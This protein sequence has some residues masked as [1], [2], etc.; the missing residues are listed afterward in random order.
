[1]KLLKQLFLPLLAL[2]L[3]TG[4]EEVPD[5]DPVANFEALWQILDERYCFFD[6]KGVDWDQV[7]REY[8][9]KI[10]D[11][12]SERDLLNIL[13]Q[14]TYELKDG[15]TNLIADSYSVSPWNWYEDHLINFDENIQK[16]YLHQ[17]IQPD[18]ESG[19]VYN[20]LADGTIG[21]IYYGSFD[22]QV[23]EEILDEI[24]GFM[25]Q[26]IALI[27][28]VRNN[29][30]GSL[31]YADRI[32]SRFTDEKIR[33]GY[34][35]HK[36]G[37]GHNDFSEPFPIV[38]APT[39]ARKQW[40]KPVVVLTN[41]RCFSAANEFVN[42]M[43]ATKQSTVIGDRTGGGSGFPFHSELPNGWGIRFSA[44]PVL[45]SYKRQTEQGIAPSIKVD[46]SDEDRK[47]G[48]DSI[49]ETAIE[50]IQTRYEK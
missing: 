3:L 7:Y 13:T 15:H 27:V 25:S 36:T 40:L 28:D 16:N 10:S 50:Y 11:N 1:M 5:N 44:S 35:L 33:T 46:M 23:S 45:D 31:S 38:L 48:K 14:M 47:E 24:F 18:A 26:C 42:K 19:I 21:Y 6:Y 49:I 9:P 37:P 30:G 4:C 39:Q 22:K 8:R 29:T 12:M 34:I 43:K 32:A 2:T 41:R 17:S 20:K